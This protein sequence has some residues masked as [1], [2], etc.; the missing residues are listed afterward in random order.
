MT[1]AMSARVRRPVRN[2]CAELAWF[3]TAICQANAH[4]D[5]TTATKPAIQW[6]A[7]SAT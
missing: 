6:Y 1:P 2:V 7:R 5:A 3:T 4:V